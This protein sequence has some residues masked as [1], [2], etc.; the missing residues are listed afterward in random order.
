MEFWSGFDGLKK[1]KGRLS[2]VVFV[3]LY[4]KEI[5]WEGKEEREKERVWVMDM[6]FDSVLVAL[7]CI[8]RKAISMELA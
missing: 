8:G 3:F 1:E 7:F 5:H 6:V 2:W 4:A